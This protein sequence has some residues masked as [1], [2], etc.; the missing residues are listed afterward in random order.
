MK[1]I[2]L[3]L[4]LT[5]TTATAQFTKEGTTTA[6]F[7]KL[8]VGARA[9][10]MAGAAVAISDDASAAYWNPAGLAYSDGITVALMHNDW[11]LDI[12]HD[13]VSLAVPMGNTGILGASITMLSMGKQEI[14]TPTEPGGTGIDYSVQDFAIALSYARKLTNRLNYGLSVKYVHLTAHNEKASTLAIDMGSILETGFYGVKIGMSMSNFGGN[15]RY[16][17][18]DLITDSQVNDALDRDFSPDA[19]MLTESWPLPM[20]IRVGLAGDILGAGDGMLASEFHRLTFALDA[21]HP[22]D[23]P[24]HVNMGLE[25]ALRETVFLR[26]GYRMFYELEGTTFGAGTSFTLPGVGKAKMDIAVI[27]MGVFG[28]I[29]RISLELQ[30]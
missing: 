7:L 16:E 19:N 10:G 14:T 29:Q 30:F 3:I 17:G 2:S 18:R 8:G 28:N 25:Y 1:Y 11:I 21:I 9:L 22:N 15:L 24:E 5:F 27:P 26:A 12:S 23:A 20:I 13:F 6:Q 4:V